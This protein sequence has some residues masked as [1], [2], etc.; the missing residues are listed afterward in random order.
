L[1]A[2]STKPSIEGRIRRFLKNLKK[3]YSEFVKLSDSSTD[4]KHQDIKKFEEYIR[5]LQGQELED[6]LSSYEKNY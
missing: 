3:K 1:E 2:Y 5:S 6:F 4:N